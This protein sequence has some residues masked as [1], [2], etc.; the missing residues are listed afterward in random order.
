MPRTRPQRLAG[1][2]PADRP[3]CFY[4]ANRCRQTE[5]ARSLAEFLFDDET[6]MVRIDMSEYMEKH[7]VRV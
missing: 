6:A 1:S 2:R 5:L 4:G 7:T 3:F